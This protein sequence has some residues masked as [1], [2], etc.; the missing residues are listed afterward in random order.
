MNHANA[1]W[2]DPLWPCL[3]APTQLLK[4]KK[5]KGEEERKDYYKD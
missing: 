3:L 4:K 5:K 2:D 1:A